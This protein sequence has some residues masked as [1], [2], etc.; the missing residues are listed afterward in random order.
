MKA[1]DNGS[2]SFLSALTKQGKEPNAFIHLQFEIF[3][4]DGRDLFGI[5]QC[6]F[7]FVCVG[8]D[9]GSEGIPEFC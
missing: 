8:V 7:F 1:F 9:D 5:F 4:R 2:E 6:Y 3:L